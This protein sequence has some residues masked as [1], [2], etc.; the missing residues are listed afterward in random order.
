MASIGPMAKGG[1]LISAFP[2][3]VLSFHSVCKWP[4]QTSGI[5]HILLLCHLME[6]CIDSRSQWQVFHF[7][8]FLLLHEGIK[9][10][11]TLGNF[12]VGSS[13]GSSCLVLLHSKIEYRAERFPIY[14]LPLLIHTSPIINILIRMIHLWKSMTHTDT[15]LSP[16]AHSFHWGALDVVHSLIWIN[17]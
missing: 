3:I 16:K 8:Q 2:H 12:S 10:G 13:L 5:P 4:L 9:G 1:V 6:A 11:Y 17:V 15:L 14:S 7:A